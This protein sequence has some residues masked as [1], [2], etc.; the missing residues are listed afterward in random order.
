MQV[1]VWNDNVHP[2]EQEIAGKKY[3]LEAKSFIE[4]DED[5]A[6]TLVKRFSPIILGGDEQPIPESYK[7]LRVDKEDLAK[8]R[9]L[10]QN[11]GRAGSYVCQAC[12]YVCANKW[13]LDGHT[14][15]LHADQWEDRDEARASINAEKSKKKRG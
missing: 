2:F 7:M 1:R 4:L 3:R 13:E 9:S 14:Q 10:R 12:G 15:D 8:N 11:Q 5:E 6:D